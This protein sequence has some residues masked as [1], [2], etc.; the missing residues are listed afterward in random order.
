MAKAMSNA[1]VTR[2][3]ETLLF[4]VATLPQELKIVAGFAAPAS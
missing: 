3:L 2:E 1:E 4:D